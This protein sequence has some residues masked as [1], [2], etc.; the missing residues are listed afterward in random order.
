MAEEKNGNL[1]SEMERRLDDLFDDDGE[2]N[3]MPLQESSGS[4]SAPQNG[5][6]DGEEEPPADEPTL[7]LDEALPVQE[8]ESPL[9]E[10]KATVLSMDWE[11]TDDV[12][13]RLLDQ[14]RT[15]KKDLK[16]DRG[17]FLLLQV[18]GALG[19]YIKTNKGQAHP[20]AINVLKSVYSALET[21]TESNDLAES[22][23]KN[24]LLAEVR[25][26]KKLKDQIV[27]AVAVQDV[28]APTEAM[29][30]E[31]DMVPSPGPTEAII[32]AAI[33]EEIKKIVQRVVREEF[34]AL[35]ADLKVMRAK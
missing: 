10:L 29:V 9:T 6:E 20:N 30:S 26:F 2:P 25:K 3:D 28:P 8:T 4:K 31:P 32:P 34:E 19:K 15:V 16:S 18:L 27:P 33:I 35:R 22:D 13:S 23:K 14:I 12:L 11:I 24:I 1:S 21:V 17:S 7:T 5:D